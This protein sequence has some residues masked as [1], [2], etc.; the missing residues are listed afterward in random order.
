MELPRG[1]EA[2]I[3]PSIPEIPYK[4]PEKGPFAFLFRTTGTVG[5]AQNI[6]V[7]ATDADTTGSDGSSDNPSSN[8][9]LDW[10]DDEK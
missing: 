7:T 3:R 5:A 9:K 4:L 1:L 2:S 6:G 8:E 10:R